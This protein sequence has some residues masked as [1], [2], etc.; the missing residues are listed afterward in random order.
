MTESNQGRE[1]NQNVNPKNPNPQ[2]KE[3]RP[4]EPQQ[5]CEQKNFALKDAI[6]A[7][8]PDN[9]DRISVRTFNGES[10]V[11]GLEAGH[12]RVIMRDYR[13][14]V[15]E[16]AKK[17]ETANNGIAARKNDGLDLFPGQIEEQEKLE[18]AFIQEFQSSGSLKIREGLM[19]AVVG[20]EKTRVPDPSSV[21]IN[22][23]ESRIEAPRMK[24]MVKTVAVS[25]G[26]EKRRETDLRVFPGDDP[27]AISGAGKHGWL[28]YLPAPRRHEV[29][30]LAIAS[31]DDT[32]AQ[33]LV[34]YMGKVA[35]G[36]ILY[37]EVAEEFAKIV[38]EPLAYTL[39][40]F[41]NG[42]P[43]KSSFR[44]PLANTALAEQLKAQ[45]AQAST[46]N[47][48]PQ[49]EEPETPVVEAEAAPETTDEAESAEIIADAEPV[50]ATPEKAEVAGKRQRGK[51][52]DEAKRAR[53]MG[54][55][56]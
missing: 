12:G 44:E 29:V 1:Q 2:Q 47:L 17:L 15:I 45:A 46:E 22:I 49:E 40:A 10:H 32:V 18:R 38:P 28:M 13:T 23:T 48:A 37:V 54:D 56:E 5:R 16:A 43:K 6:V 27:H 52:R 30:F 34:F 4:M 21:V 8:R 14:N 53:A 7:V 39:E 41:A 42:G 50:P 11:A 33:N 55:N 26:N 3:R 25:D 9:L 20:G 36:G 35:G 31:A 19:Q 24:F 51:S